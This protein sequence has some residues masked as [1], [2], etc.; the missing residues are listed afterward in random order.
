MEGQ[1][2][3][4]PNRMLLA[5]R[6]HE[7][8]RL[9]LLQHQPH[10]FHIV[11]RIAPIAQAVQI[12]QIQLLLQAAGNA[13]S[14]QRDFAGNK[15]F[16]PPLRLVIEQNA[17][18]GINAVC[19]AVFLYDPVA[20]LLGNR[21]GAVRME[22]RSLPLRALLHLAEQFTGGSLVHPAGLFQPQNVN[23]LQ[24]AQHA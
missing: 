24:N 3:K 9:I 14:R 16:A 12:A 10:T 18:A 20:I 19:F 15:I 8:V 13:C 4:L 11:L 17:V 7:V 2:R 5:G 1:L 21:I 6:N 22:G 23:C